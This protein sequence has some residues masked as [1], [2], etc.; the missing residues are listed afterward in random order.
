M[1]VTTYLVLGLLL[2]TSLQQQ[3][4][5]RLVAPECRKVQGRLPILKDDNPSSDNGR[6]GEAMG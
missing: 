1:A 6:G 2:S 3:R 5:D 4:H